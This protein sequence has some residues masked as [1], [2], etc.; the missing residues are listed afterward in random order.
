MKFF[1][2]KGQHIV[3]KAIARR[4]AGYAELSKK[5]TVLEV[6]CGTGVLTSVLLE[7]AGKVYGIE[8]DARF[9]KLLQEKFAKEI[10]EG[11]FIL[12]HGDAMK[13]EFP[14]F[15]KFVSNIPYFISSPLT[16]KLLR[17]D[18]DVA[19]VM[20]QREFAERLVARKGE[21]YG[22]LSVVVKAYAKPEI[23]EYVSR[24][25]FRPPPSVDSAVVRLIKKPEIEVENLQ[26]FEDLVRY[27]FSRRRKQLGKILDEW[28]ESRGIWLEVP[29]ELRRLRPEDIEPEVYAEIVKSAKL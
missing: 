14:P 10:D 24:K 26:I 29:E 1:K 6:G 20:Y 21:N 3:S 11:R 9:V 18:F 16:F 19:V 8:I 22:R 5:D 17:H 4:I 12:I 7:R 25:A 15:N 28:M 23:V 13:V 27:C 2:S